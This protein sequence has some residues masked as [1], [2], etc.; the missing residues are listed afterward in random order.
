MARL[1]PIAM[2]LLMAAT[3]RSEAR[4]MA[5]TYAREVSR[6]RPPFTPNLAA[7]VPKAVRFDLI[8][9]A[10]GDLVVETPHGTLTARVSVHGMDVP[11]QGVV[12]LFFDDE[13]MVELP[14]EVRPQ[15]HA[16]R[17]KTSNAAADVHVYPCS[18]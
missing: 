8:H 6:R 1:V 15:Q 16:R 12:G 7:G 3:R 17:R 5:D 14:A 4:G 10:V 18:G 11:E 13:P 9:P 2:V